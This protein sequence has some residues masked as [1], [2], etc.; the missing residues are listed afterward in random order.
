MAEHDPPNV[1]GID[2]GG[3]AF[4]G[5]G[6]AARQFVGRDNIT[7]VT[8]NVA[9]AELAAL[10]ATLLALLATPGVRLQAGEVAAAGRTVAVPPELADA[11]RKFLDAA[12]GPT[13]AERERQY[14]L[15]LCVDPDFQQWQQRYVALAGGYRAVPELTPA[16]SAILVRGEGP[17]RQIER[18]ALPD[19]RRPWTST[20]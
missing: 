11:L 16:Y 6:V 8:I 4:V 15:R 17:Q 2:T 20:T 14:L 12:P 7:N 5:G 1:G 18:V 19:I 3:G 13:Q 10:A 9:G